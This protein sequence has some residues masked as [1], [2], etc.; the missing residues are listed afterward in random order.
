M[1]F[2]CIKA[3]L[4]TGEAEIESFSFFVLFFLFYLSRIISREMMEE[5]AALCVCVCMRVIF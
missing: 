3:L 1:Q 2:G 4:N 5:S